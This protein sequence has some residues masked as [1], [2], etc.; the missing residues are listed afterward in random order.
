MCVWVCVCV[1]VCDGTLTSACGYLCST[2]TPGST[3]K[4]TNKK[5]GRY[6]PPK[7]SKVGSPELDFFFFL[8]ESVFL[9]TNFC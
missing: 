6:V 2:Q 7:S 8:L 3:Q 5:C 9:G 4:Q 1:C